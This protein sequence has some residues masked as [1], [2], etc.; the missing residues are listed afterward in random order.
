MAVGRYVAH[1]GGGA[2]GTEL[3]ARILAAVARDGEPGMPGSRSAAVVKRAARA[4]VYGELGRRARSPR[5]RL[6]RLAARH[7]GCSRTPQL[8]HRRAGGAISEHDL[9]VLYRHLDGCSHCA[10]LAGRCDLAEWHLNVDLG[11]PAEASDTGPGRPGRRPPLPGAAAEVEGPGPAAPPT[12]AT[13]SLWGPPPGRGAPP[14]PPGRT[15]RRLGLAAV[16]AV[17]ALAGGAAVVFGRGA[18]AHRHTAPAP[19]PALSP[20]PVPAAHGLRDPFVV[21]AARYAVFRD[22]RQGWTGFV[23]TDPGRGRKW[24]AVTVRVR[25][26]R[27]TGFDPRVLDYRVYDRSGTAYAPAATLGTGPALGRPAHPLSP[28]ELVEVRLGFRLARGAT[29]LMLR[30]APVPGGEAIVVALGP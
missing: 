18:H 5:Q 28:G 8:L 23:G 25:N 2:D 10:G 12:T 14:P 3:T 29:G 24:L 7:W 4:A 1:N 15:P 20:A 13:L 21:G 26:L 27:M 22:P 19:G 9:D 17:V 11:G 30:F 6:E 16:V